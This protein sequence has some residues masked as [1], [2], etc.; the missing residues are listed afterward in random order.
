MVRTT[1]RTS[2]SSPPP[3]PIPASLHPSPPSI[4]ARFHPSPQRKQGNTPGHPARRHAAGTAKLPSLGDSDLPPWTEWCAQQ[5]GHPPRLLHLRRSRLPSIQAPRSIPPVHPGFPSSKPPVHPF[6]PAAQAR[7]YARPPRT[8]PR[9]RDGKGSVARRFRLATRD[10][11]VRTT[12]R[13]SSSSPP[14][15]PIPATVR[16]CPCLESRR[17]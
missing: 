11:V 12:S 8:T 2:S 15:S 4:P 17:C 1:S 6:K 10:G 9:R 3:S 7:E 16:G 13:T 5:V 14:P